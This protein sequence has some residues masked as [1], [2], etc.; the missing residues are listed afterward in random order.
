MQPVDFGEE[1][2]DKGF[3]VF[4]VDPSR[5]A[6][7]RLRGSGAPQFRK[8][9]ARRFVTVEAKPREA[10]PTPEVCAAIARASIEDAIVRLEAHVTPE[11]ER[12]FRRAEVQRA[13]QD[14]HVVA[15]IRTIVPGQDAVGQMPPGVTVQTASPIEALDTYLRARQ[16]A[17]DRRVLLRRAAED[18]MASSGL[19]NA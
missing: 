7:D 10:D 6:G 2:Q 18:L 19:V 15:G 11:Q 5:R 3:M 17:D 16:L 8:V 14:A 4:D 12:L 1:G 13:L 9:R